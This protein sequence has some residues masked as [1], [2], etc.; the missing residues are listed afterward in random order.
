L[1]SLSVFDPTLVVAAAALGYRTVVR[2]C[3]FLVC[4]EGR[5][6]RHVGKGF[7]RQRLMTLFI[8]TLPAIGLAERYGLQQQAAFGFAGFMRPQ[9]EAV[10]AVSALRVLSVHWACVW[11]VMHHSFDR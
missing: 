10:I 1:G 6:R 4:R 2:Y 9:R 3:R 11:V 8:I 7:G 5:H